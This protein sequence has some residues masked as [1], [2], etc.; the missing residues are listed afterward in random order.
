MECLESATERAVLHIELDAP[1]NVGFDYQ[2]GDHLG[3]YPANDSLYVDQ[4]GKRLNLHLDAA[5]RLSLL[6][7]VLQSP[8][9]I[10]VR[11]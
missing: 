7:G 2:P 10:D 5:F 8:P 9:M 1:K 4:L 11:S 3:L 6:H